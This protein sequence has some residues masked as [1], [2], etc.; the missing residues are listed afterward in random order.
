MKAAIEALSEVPGR[1]ICVL[2]DMFEL[3]DDSKKMHY[4]VGRFAAEKGVSILFVCGEQSVDIAKGA[5]GVNPDADLEGCAQEEHI[6]VM[7]TD[8]DAAVIPEFYIFKDNC[9][10][11]NKIKEIIRPEDTVLVKASNSMKF[12]EV[13]EGLKTD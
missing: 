9:R 3:G 13:V 2:G 7:M 1:R 10:M 6:E 5:L 4:D 12:S 8:P 11:I